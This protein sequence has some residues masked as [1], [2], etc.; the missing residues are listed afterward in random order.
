MC[1]QYLPAKMFIS[2]N[3][4]LF[5]VGLGTFKDGTTPFFNTKR[6]PYLLA[7]KSIKSSF[8]KWLKQIFKVS[9]LSLLVKLHAFSHSIRTL[10]SLGN[11]QNKKVNQTKMFY[12]F[13][14]LLTNDMKWPDDLR[15][16]NSNILY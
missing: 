12:S 10:T 4:A 3:L 16:N 9:T 13:M 2:A 15:I 11:L 8:L 14:H 6:P 5:T 7:F 1:T